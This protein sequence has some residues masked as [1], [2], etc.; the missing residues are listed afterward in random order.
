MTIK[1]DNTK[2]MDKKEADKSIDNMRKEG[3]GSGGDFYVK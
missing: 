1:S 2:Y 3:L